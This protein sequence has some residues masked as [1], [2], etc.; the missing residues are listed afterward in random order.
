VKQTEN[1]WSKIISN[2]RNSNIFSIVISIDSGRAS[3]ENR[4]REGNEVT[5]KLYLSAPI[6][7]LST[8]LSTPEVPPSLQ[9]SR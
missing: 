2:N 5:D 9:L 1:C 4:Q 7:C 3:S 8:S 6:L